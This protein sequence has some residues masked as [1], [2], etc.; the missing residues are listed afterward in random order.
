LDF[1]GGFQDMVIID[2]IYWWLLVVIGI[3]WWDM[4]FI[5]GYWI[6]F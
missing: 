2:G 3:Y 1:T 4:R 6:L 5:G